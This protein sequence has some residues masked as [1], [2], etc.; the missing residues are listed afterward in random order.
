MGATIETFNVPMFEILANPILRMCQT[1]GI[2]PPFDPCGPSDLGST[3]TEFSHLD[4][5]V[6]HGYS[7]TQQINFALNLISHQSQNN[8]TSRSQSALP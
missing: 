6:I 5:F 1:G 8:N 2:I 3:I 7:G 4:E